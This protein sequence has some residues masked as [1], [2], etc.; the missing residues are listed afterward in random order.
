MVRPSQQRNSRIPGPFSSVGIAL[1]RSH[2]HRFG[3]PSGMLLNDTF[4]S[5]G[6]DFLSWTS[7]KVVE[8]LLSQPLKS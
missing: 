2:H 3:D 1:N 8:I 7:I 5:M 4:I 6:F